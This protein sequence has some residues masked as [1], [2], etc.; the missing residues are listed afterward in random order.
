MEQWRTEL[1][2]ALHKGLE[3]SNE[4]FEENLMQELFQL[5][6]DETSSSSKRSKIG[7]STLGRR[8]VHRD[9]KA[10]DEQLY[11]DYFALN[12]TFD[13]LK[14]RRCFRMRRDLFLHIVEEVCAFDLG[15]FRSVMM[16]VG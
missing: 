12:C 16:L 6:L 3:D 15:L 8:H 11:H 14:F 10:C 9:R 7:G 1:Q 4:E 13:A 2:G 5:L